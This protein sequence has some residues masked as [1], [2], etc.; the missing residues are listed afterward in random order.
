MPTRA[1]A[2]GGTG[3]VAHRDAAH[4]ANRRRTKFSPDPT[5]TS[6]GARAMT[7]VSPGVGLSRPRPPAATTRQVY[8]R[9]DR[10]GQRANM[11]SRPAAASAIAYSLLL[12]RRCSRASGPRLRFLFA[13]ETCGPPVRSRF[14]PRS[15]SRHD[16]RVM[17]QKAPF[18]S[19]RGS[20][21]GAP[22]MQ[23]NAACH[24][25]RPGDRPERARTLAPLRARACAQ[26]HTRRSVT[27]CAQP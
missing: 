22:Y 12:A 6:S 20:V 18:S 23:Q 13:A 26:I 10:P 16:S 11:K 17:Q 3:R 24:T 5:R 4:G 19:Q 7:Y 25:L 8:H 15:G 2:I 1:S 27:G 21:P 9:F 14:A